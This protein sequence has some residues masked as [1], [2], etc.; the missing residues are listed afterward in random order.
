ML[1]ATIVT[2]TAELQQILALQ[3]RNLKQN[4]SEGEKKEQGFVTMQS[5]LPMLE[6]IHALAP[7]IIVKDGDKVIGY[8]LVLLPEGRSLYPDLDPLFQLFE[9]LQ[10]KDKPVSHYRF[11]IMGQVCVD[12][13]YRGQGVFDLLYQTH[14]E[15]YSENYDF[16]ITDI[17]SSNQRSIRAHERVGFK[18]IHTYRDVLDEW[19]VVLWN[20]EESR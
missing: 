8:A 7:S 19:E 5:T 14:K 2:T 10:W 15:Y 18:I 6:S 1:S 13:D 3:Q 9:T 11:Y 20:W 4:I 17:S 12:K 16:I